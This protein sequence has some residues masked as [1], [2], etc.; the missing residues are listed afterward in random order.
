MAGLGSLFAIGCYTAW[1]GHGN[2]VT[3]A[4]YE[5]QESAEPAAD[6][7]RA[8]WASIGS[9]LTAPTSTNAYENVIDL[10]A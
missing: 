8:V 5:S 9:M 2:I 4:L 6:W 1:T 3:T 7:I 10:K